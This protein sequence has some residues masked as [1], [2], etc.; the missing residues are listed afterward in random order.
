MKIKLRSLA[1]ILSLA[2]FMGSVS[3]CSFEP[4]DNTPS[5]PA[6]SSAEV[7]GGDTVSSG[8]KY[9]DEIFSLNCDMEAGLNPYDTASSANMELVPLMYEGLFAVNNDFSFESVLCEEYSTNDGKVYRFDIRKGI[10]LHDGSELT[11]EDVAASIELAR[12]SDNYATRLSI[13]TAAYVLEDSVY[14]ELSRPNY[15]LPLLLD[16]P[17]VKAGSGREAVPVGTGPYYYV[18]AG[19]YSYLKA[20]DGHRS[21]AELPTERF[22]LKEYSGGELITAFDSGLVDLVSTSKADINY[23]EYSGNTESRQ[24]DTTIL[25]FLGVNTNNKFLSD[26]NRRVLLSSMIDRQMLSEEIITAVPTTI[27]LHPSAYFYSEDYDSFAIKNRDIE[28]AKIEYLVEDYDAD[29]M[30][31]F[32]DLEAGTV[33]EISLKLVVNKE[34]PTKVEAARAISES[35]AE[36]GIEVVVTE[37]AWS[38]YLRALRD[39]SYDLYYGEVMLTA[40]FDLTQLLTYGGSANYGVYDSR[41]QSLIYDFNSSGSDT[42]QDAAAQL[43]SYIAENLPVI[44]LMFEIETIY[45][46]RETVSGMNPAIHNIFSGIAGWSIDVE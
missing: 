4:E 40:D 21:R 37:L 43:Y 42:K 20:F 34:N 31:E 12:V 36:Q 6:D 22:Y 14:M 23:L 44:S 3:A 45:T 2:L 24:K 17:V 35:L 27:P 38:S 15:N 30:L 39:R 9:A 8:P 46:H 33:D 7:P 32:M 25:Y 1:L 5:P 16:V 28:A 11:P 19:E 13:I 26:K 41:L 29:G 10:K 18:N